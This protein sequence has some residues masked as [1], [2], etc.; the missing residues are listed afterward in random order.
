LSR[1]KSSRSWGNLKSTRSALRGSDGKLHN[2]N[3]AGTQ[4]NERVD[5]R[6]A[7]ELANVLITP[8]DITSGQASYRRLRYRPGF[9][10]AGNAHSDTK[11]SFDIPQFA[12][13]KLPCEY[14]C[15]LLWSLS[16]C[17]QCYCL[18]CRWSLG[19]STIPAFWGAPADV[20]IIQDHKP[21]TATLFMRIA[22]RGPS[23]FGRSIVQMPTKCQLIH[24]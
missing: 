24:T 17:G 23:I 22:H 8:C 7:A 11:H 2:T 19:N 1:E 3:T 16:S 6:T 5:R 4:E 15:A 13:A 9:S 12:K 20:A 18:W 10:L 21:P 14:T